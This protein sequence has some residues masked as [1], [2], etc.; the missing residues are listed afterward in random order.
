MLNTRSHG[1]ACRKALTIST[2]GMVVVMLFIVSAHAAYY[3]APS[4]NDGGDG[5]ESSPYATVAKGVSSA[6]AGDTVLLRAGVYRQSVTINKSGGSGAY[7]VIRACPGENA[8]VDGN[9]TLPTNRWTG[10]FQLNGASFVEIEGIE[11]RNSTERGVHS[12]NGS[13]IRIRN[14]RF[15]NIQGSALNI[16]TSY[17]LIENN[18]ISDCCLSNSANPGAGGSGWPGVLMVD[19]THHCTIRGN[20]VYRNWGEGIIDLVCEHTIIEDNSVWNNWALGIYLDHSAYSIVRRN[21]VYYDRDTRYWRFYNRPAMGI[22]ISNESY[23]SDVTYSRGRDQTIV[24]NL[25]SRC[26]DG[27][28][29]F[30][31]GVLEGSRLKNTLVANNTFVDSYRR[32][33]AISTPAGSLHENVRF[34]NNIVVQSG[35]TMAEADDTRGIAFLSNCWSAWVD[36]KFRSDGDINGDPGLL[37]TGSTD[38][39]AL[40]P[41]YFRL[42]DGSPCIDNA[43]VIAEVTEDFFGVA[44]GNT[45]DIG[46]YEW[47]EPTGTAGS[48]PSVH[49]K[50]TSAVAQR[51]TPSPCVLINGR[52]IAADTR[53]KAR[54]SPMVRVLSSNSQLPGPAGM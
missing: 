36:P 45:P 18:D 39:G 46:A 52:L 50:R 6:G 38:G 33:I 26:G 1:H 19:R 5:S 44:R 28:S 34:A 9:N 2:A 24:N 40:S 48:R 3:V 53:D 21:V 31:V 15:R 51:H 11:I 7:I 29:F 4:G 8:V 54:R 17:S 41:D 37:R 10:L 22:A 32:G 14:C 43:S 47:E 42:S 16:R 49:S 12:L 27:F 23:Y 35:G 20:H 30:K 13:N 25:V